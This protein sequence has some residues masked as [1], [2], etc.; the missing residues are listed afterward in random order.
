MGAT[1]TVKIGGDYACFTRAEFKVERVSYRVITPSAARGVLEA[2]FWKPEV[3]WRIREIG[4]LRPIREMAI[5]RNELAE[6]QG[7]V[8]VFVER[9]RQQRTSLI[10][11]DVAY[12]LVAELDL[13]PHATD[14]LSKYTDQFRR[15]V[16]RGQNHHTPYLGCREFSAWFEPASGDEE[17]IP[18]DLDLGSMLFDIAYV[19]DP[20]R[21]D[22]VNFW[23]RDGRVQ[24]SV[25]GYAEAIFFHAKLVRGKLVVPPEKYAELD[26][27]ERGHA[28]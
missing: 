28:S 19:E 10:L 17:T 20:E 2:I 24:R 4:V 14:P 13:R 11:K 15:R 16:E 22:R 6:R 27:R 26:R 23:R 5:L 9:Q 1:F 8:P 25:A 7:G 3:R 12:V 18:V 21:T